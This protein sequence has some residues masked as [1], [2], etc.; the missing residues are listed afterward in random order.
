[1]QW[2]VVHAGAARSARSEI[3][4]VEGKMS[5]RSEV[6]Y[7]INIARSDRNRRWEERLL[8]AAI[9]FI[10]KRHGAELRSIAF[11]Q[12]PHVRPAICGV[13]F[14]KANAGNESIYSGS[15]SH[16]EFLVPLV[17]IGSVYRIFSCTTLLGSL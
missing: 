10:G 4:I 12:M 11:P 1:M 8:P 6:R 13:S 2:A 15:E 17:G 3:E 14:I 5:L 7:D 9:R 16:T